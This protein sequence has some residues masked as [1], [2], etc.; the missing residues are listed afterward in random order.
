MPGDVAGFVGGMD[1]SCSVGQLSL[2]GELF[3]EEEGVEELVPV[4]DLQEGEG[5][6]DMLA[7]GDVAQVVAVVPAERTGVQSA[8]PLGSGPAVA[9]QE[10]AG[11]V[12]LR[13]YHAS[14]VLDILMPPIAEPA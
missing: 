3:S 8:S 6:G 2:G 5:V 9:A 7:P 12:D 13:R 11:H 4:S 10:D 14:E 1:C